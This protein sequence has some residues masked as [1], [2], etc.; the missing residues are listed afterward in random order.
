MEDDLNSPA[1]PIP[2]QIGRVSVFGRAVVADAYSPE[3]FM[4]RNY[5]L[6]FTYEVGSDRIGRGGYWGDFFFR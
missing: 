1:I 6:N 3:Q 5:C 2:I 4:S